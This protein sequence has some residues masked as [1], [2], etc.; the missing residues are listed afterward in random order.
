MTGKKEAE[1]YLD[2]QVRYQGQ[3][4]KVGDGDYWEDEDKVTR[5][6]DTKKESYKILENSSAY[7][8]MQEG[9][10]YTEFHRLL[11]NQK[12]NV[13]F[14][15]IHIYYDEQNEE[16]KTENLSNAVIKAYYSQKEES[17]EFQNVELNS[18]PKLSRY[19]EMSFE[20]N[21]LTIKGTNADPEVD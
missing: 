20:N 2:I 15:L 6:F 14:Q 5:K 10:I 4:I 17:G 1:C 16:R 8:P 3:N 19:A 11:V 18:K 13:R 7:R 12:I 9:D 21:T